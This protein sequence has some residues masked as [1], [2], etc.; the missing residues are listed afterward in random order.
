MA[1]HIGWLDRI[2]CTGRIVSATVRLHFGVASTPNFATSS[3]AERY[4]SV[5]L[6]LLRWFRHAV[7][8]PTHM[9]LVTTPWSSFGANERMCE[10]YV[11]Q[12]MDGVHCSEFTHTHTQCDE[13][14]FNGWQEYCVNMPLPQQRTLCSLSMSWWRQ[15]AL[16]KWKE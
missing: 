3:C 5:Y 4:H 13:R 15:L 8:K 16:R 1:C 9:A 11:R 6:N 2:Y 7:S 14:A 12:S 10:N